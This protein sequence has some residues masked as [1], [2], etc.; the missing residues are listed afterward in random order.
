MVITDEF[1]DVIAFDMETLLPIDCDNYHNRNNDD[2][3]N[4]DNTECNTLID[5]YIIGNMSEEKAI[6]K[7]KKNTSFK[8][9]TI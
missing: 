4:A 2:D 7:L 5:K 3:N 9:C 8:Y 1:K 6:K